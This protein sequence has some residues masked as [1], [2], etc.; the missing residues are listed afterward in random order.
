MDNSLID[1]AKAFSTLTSSE[2]PLISN[3]GDD[4]SSEST[5]ITC[6]YIFDAVAVT[7]KIPIIKVRF[8]MFWVLWLRYHNMKILFGYQA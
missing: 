8:F 2:S 7:I 1:W 4:V 6:P 3:I 5:V